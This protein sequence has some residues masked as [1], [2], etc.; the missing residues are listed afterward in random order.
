VDGLKLR[1]E[2]SDEH[3]VLKELPKEG[4]GCQILRLQVS[5]Y[6][7]KKAQSL[8]TASPLSAPACIKT[9]Q[10][11]ERFSR[12]RPAKSLCSRASAY[13]IRADV[14]ESMRCRSVHTIK[15]MLN[16]LTRLEVQPEVPNKRTPDFVIIWISKD[17]WDST[18][19]AGYDKRCVFF[20]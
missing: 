2:V 17:C 3:N 16:E 6:V 11:S 9:V 5:I 4:F 7:M 1:K 14:L 13:S 15:R 18:E 19:E 10:I 8:L 20:E 12:S